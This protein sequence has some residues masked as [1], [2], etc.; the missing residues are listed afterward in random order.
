MTIFTPLNIISIMKKLF[1]VAIFCFN[2]LFAEENL[3]M[4]NTITYITNITLI[5]NIIITSPEILK[6]YLHKER[7]FYIKDLRYNLLKPIWRSAVLPGWGQYYNGSW[8]KAVIFNSLFFITLGGGIIYYI[9]SENNYDKYKSITS[10]VEDYKLKMGKYWDAYME[11]HAYSI[12]FF[13]ATGMVYLYN[14]A[15][16]YIDAKKPKYKPYYFEV[17][18]NGV[19]LKLRF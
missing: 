3:Q 17:S 11:N 10:T 12:S 5:T 6:N 13:V 14:I 15:D 2:F 8:T 19:E 16:A 4:T 7:Q 1:F 18:M 9:K